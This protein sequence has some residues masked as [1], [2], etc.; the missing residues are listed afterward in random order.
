MASKIEFR[1]NTAAA[2]TSTNPIL[3][4]GE[5]GVELDTARLKVGDGVTPWNTLP[6][7][8][9]DTTTYITNYEL[10]ISP[11]APSAPQKG[12]IWIQ[13]LS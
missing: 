6:Y 13:T 7:A 4:A 3:D 8:A 1:R 12:M 9:I 10:V 5:P 11:V 2:W